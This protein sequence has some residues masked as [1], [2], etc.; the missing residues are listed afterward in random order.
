MSRTLTSLVALLL[1]ST[2]L[3][4]YFKPDRHPSFK[5][6]HIPIGYDLTEQQLDQTSVSSYFFISFLTTTNEDKFFLLSHVLRADAEVTQCK[7]SILNLKSLQ[8]WDEVS[9]YNS[10]N[11]VSEGRLDMRHGEYG[12]IGK[13]LDSISSVQFFGASPEYSFDLT[14]E[15]TYRVLLNGG[16]GAFTFGPEYSNTTE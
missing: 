10:S 13:S 14:L 3:A 15:A 9:L 8:R 11:A 2:S 1:A 4:Y 7:S 5:N 16:T 12:V 6:T